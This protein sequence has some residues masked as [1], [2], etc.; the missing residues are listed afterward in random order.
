MMRRILT[1]S[2]RQND[3]LN[4]RQQG[5][6]LVVVVSLIVVMMIM[7][8]AFVDTS[9]KHN[10]SAESYFENRRSFYLADAG[11]NE[12]VHVARLGGLG[13]LGS[14]ATPV[15]MG[16]GLFW[17]DA[18]DIGGNELRLVCTA[19]VGSGRTSLEVIVDSTFGL[20]AP[21]FDNVLNSSLAPLML[22]SNAM[23]DSYVS[24]D[25]TY[26]SQVVNT[27]DGV[28]YAGDNAWIRS[29]DDV[30]ISTNTRV[31]GDAIPGPTK[32]VVLAGASS[33]VSGS[34]TPATKNFTFT[35]IVPPVAASMGDY[36][37]PAGV[38]T[39]L[40]AGT[41]GFDAFTVPADAI[42]RIEGPCDIVVS[43]F[44]GLNKG[45]LEIDARLG[46]VT[47]YCMG[48]YSQIGGFQTVPYADSPGALAFMVDG[49]Q[50]IDFG[51]GASVYGAF[52]APEANVTFGSNC[53]FWGSM[54]AGSVVMDSN[55]NFHFDESLLD[56]WLSDTGQGDDEMEFVAWYEAS[57]PTA[58]ASNRLD[59]YTALELTEADVLTIAE[60]RALSL[61]GAP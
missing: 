15:S 59:P 31:F 35:P 42:L 26:A 43:S 45:V 16:G 40:P 52:Y 11:I 39:V 38:V 48:P 50:D 32:T 6:T 57:V 21:L 46:P 17:V 54:T 28:D 22:A 8:F 2:E 4:A 20:N 56:Y 23:V 14:A 12:A 51:A 33:Y 47:V 18:T 36:T 55:M 44:A 60:A 5:S 9:I 49:V 53:E 3:T 19:L 58:L 30:F 7:G 37:A 13:S 29:A 41:H 24:A 34:T 10:K 25:G 61:A 27:Y 1:C